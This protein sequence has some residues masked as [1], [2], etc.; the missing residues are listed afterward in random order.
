MGQTENMIW[1]V[2]AYL[3]Y[4][5]PPL[6]DDVL[7]AAERELG[8]RLPSEFVA[9][10]RIQNG[11]YIRCSLPD[12]VH[13]TIAGIGP[14]FPSLTDFDWDEC[15]EFVSFPLHGL[16][17]FDGD[18]HWH[19]CLD[20]RRNSLSPAVT[21]VDIECD[22]QITI[23]PSFSNYL[24]LLQLET[25]GK[26]VLENVSDIEPIKSQLGGILGVPFSKPESWAYGYP[27]ERAALGNQE[28]PEWLWLTPNNVPRGFV[29]ADDPRYDE[30]KD[31]L[32]G[33]A[34]RYP[35]IPENTYLL[36]ATNGVLSRVLDACRQ[37][38]FVVRPL[39]DYLNASQ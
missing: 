24:T 11:G 15:Q 34:L 38:H 26:Y 10:L 27:V 22:Y 37:S 4:L 29:R 30:L 12:S 28:C 14:N 18:G 13:D 2:P 21:H 25:D 33:T 5:Q 19:L 23:A 31:L 39:H 20:Y 6:T 9:L 1:E 7:A 3:P 32:P 35:E 16:V 17:P 36:S 8:F